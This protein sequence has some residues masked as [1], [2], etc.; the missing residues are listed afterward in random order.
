MLQP[1]ENKLPTKPISC[2]GFLFGDRSQPDIE[3]YAKHSKT[4]ITP[5]S[6][7]KALPLGAD[8]SR[9]RNDSS[10]KTTPVEVDVLAKMVTYLGEL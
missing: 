10:C 1:I 9:S 6:A 2:Y 3:R 8:F 7:T 4:A 5:S